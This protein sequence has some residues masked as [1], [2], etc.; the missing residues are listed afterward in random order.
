MHIIVIIFLFVICVSLGSLLTSKGLLSQTR[1]LTKGVG[2]YTYI[3]QQ[4]Q[5]VDPML[6]QRWSA[7]LAQ[8]L[9]NIGSM[10]AGIDG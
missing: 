7:T 10:F 1:T 3:S 6:I 8:H 2:L 9:I 5:Y 4:T